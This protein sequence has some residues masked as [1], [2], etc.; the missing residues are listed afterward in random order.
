MGNA[1]YPY[2]S[3]DVLKIKDENGNYI[4]YSSGYSF[5]QGKT[6]T[7]EYVISAPRHIGFWAASTSVHGI[8]WAGGSFSEY[9][10]NPFEYVEFSDYE[11]LF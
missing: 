8:Y 9:F 4:D 3:Q 10:T 11:G 6:Y 7:V 5:E 2:I 1:E